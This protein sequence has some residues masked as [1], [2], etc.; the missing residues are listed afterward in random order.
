MLIVLYVKHE[1]SYDK[2]YKDANLLF[3]VVGVV[4]K[5]NTVLKDYRY[6][7]RPVLL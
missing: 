6:R 3:R 1:L 7:L 4:N 2:F 5:D